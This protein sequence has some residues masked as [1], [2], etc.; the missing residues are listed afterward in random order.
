MSCKHVDNRPLPEVAA[1][2]QAASMTDAYHNNSSSK[3]VLAIQSGSCKAGLKSEAAAAIGPAAATRSTMLCSATC[4]SPTWQDSS[5]AGH[6]ITF[7]YRLG[8]KPAGCSFCTQELAG[9]ADQQQQQQDGQGGCE[10]QGDVLLQLEVL[11]RFNAGSGSELH[12]VRLMHD[13]PAA[14]SAAAAGA[15]ADAGELPGSRRLLF[16]K[17][18][19]FAL[20]LRRPKSSTGG[21]CQVVWPGR[22]LAV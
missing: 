21:S 1:T 18:Q 7:R 4:S 12:H 14:G 9:D 15:A 16:K 20:R 3:P 2:S 22:L 5:C 19:A 11:G 13:V 10:A 17:G 8:S 6:I